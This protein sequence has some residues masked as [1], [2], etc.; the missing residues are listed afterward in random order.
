M[1]PDII[2]G[3][4]PQTGVLVL[5]MGGIEINTKVLA[6]YLSLPSFHEVDYS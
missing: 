6:V 3:P 4:M 2:L 1:N 5:Q